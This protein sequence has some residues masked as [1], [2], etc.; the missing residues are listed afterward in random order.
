MLLDLAHGTTGIAKWW[1][2][3]AREVAVAIK[4]CY[5]QEWNKD[6]LPNTFIFLMEWQI[7]VEI[8]HSHYSPGQ[9]LGVPGV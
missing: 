4:W 7:K 5:V 1:G 2:G 9:A 3:V 6:T 8:K